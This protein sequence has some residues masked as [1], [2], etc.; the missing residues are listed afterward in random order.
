VYDVPVQVKV[1][2][3]PDLAISVDPATVR[4]TLTE[5]TG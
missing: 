2:N 4:V 3:Y 1:D 5:K